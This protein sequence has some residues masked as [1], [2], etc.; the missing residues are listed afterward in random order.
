MRIETRR[1]LTGPSVW[2]GIG[3]SLGGLARLSGF[4]RVWT[5]LIITECGRQYLNS[6]VPIKKKL[7]IQYTTKNKL[8]TIKAVLSADTDVWVES[9]PEDVEDV[10][11]LDLP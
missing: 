6:T 10:F 3:L 11:H 9:L 5:A 7:Y 8:N 4:G 1:R 2:A